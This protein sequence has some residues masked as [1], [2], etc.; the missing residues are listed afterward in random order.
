M[1]KEQAPWVLILSTPHM[2]L[3]CRWCRRWSFAFSLD[4]CTS[5]KNDGC[6]LPISIHNLKKT[7]LGQLHLYNI[8]RESTKWLD[9][10]GCYSN[11]IGPTKIK[12]PQL[13]W[14][15]RQTCSFTIPSLD[16]DSKQVEGDFWD[17]CRHH[18]QKGQSG[19]QQGPPL[20]PIRRR[21]QWR[22]H[23]RIETPS[24]A[25]TTDMAETMEKWRTI[26]LMP[27]SGTRRTSW[28]GGVH[29]TGGGG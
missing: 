9:R 7:M 25:T 22:M 27:N 13:P 12:L 23:L 14:R 15:K 20:N 3:F 19:T 2:F 17:D 24:L 29:N 6:D 16:P 8:L 28:K 21:S 11:P 1:K 10:H 5:T 18:G 26:Y 4:N